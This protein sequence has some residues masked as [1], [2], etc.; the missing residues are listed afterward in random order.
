MRFFS[1]VLLAFSMLITS[2]DAETKILF[3][4]ADTP[5]PSRTIGGFEL[6]APENLQLISDAGGK[7]V[8]W[9]YSPT[10]GATFSNA[11]AG[12]EPADRLLE[13]GLIFFK[14]TMVLDAPNGKNQIKLWVG[15]WFTGIRRFTFYQDAI[16]IKIN[17]EQIFYT[18]LTPEVVFRD[19]WCRGED[20]LFS[21]NDDVW[22]RLVKPV[23]DEYSYEVEVTDGKIHLELDGVLLSALAITR[24]DQEMEI[25]S[26]TLEQERRQDFA[27]RYPWEPQPDEPLPP[28]DPKSEK[29][30]FL[31]FQKYGDDRVFPWSRPL[32]SELSDTVRVFAARGEQEIF[33]FG[34][35]PLRELKDFDV[36]IGDFVSTTGNKL[37]LAAH[38]DFWRERYKGRGSAGTRGK[39]SDIRRLD[40]ESYVLQSM[41]ALTYEQGTPRLF[42]LDVHVPSNQEAGDY[43]APV[44]FLE[45]GKP[46]GS[47]RLQLKVLPFDL[48]YDGAAAFNFQAGYLEF[49]DST[50]LASNAF[51]REQIRK[52]VEFIAKYHFSNNFQSM[53]GW[54]FPGIV[55]LGQITG[56][57]GERSF[58]QTPEQ[59][60]MADWWFKL[61]K[62]EGNTDYLML[63]TYS[64]FSNLG[65]RIGQGK[66][67]CYFGEPDDTP[68]TLALMRKDIVRIIKQF[69]DYG[70]ENGY[71][72]FRW[73]TTGE[74]DN[75]GIEGVK[76][77]I[78]FAEL[79]R[80]AGGIN[81][82]TINGPLAAKYC[83]EFFEYLSANF[84]TPITQ[85]L[86][87]EVE[88]YGHVF[89][90]HN[91]GDTRFQAGWHFWRM[92]GGFQTP[93]NDVLYVFP[94]AAC[95]TA[96]EL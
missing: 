69:N 90:A 25:V 38:T 78:K 87:D 36:S 81:L 86:I 64:L 71:P 95:L 51:L 46:V 3:G 48:H 84:A 8:P 42:T 14:T 58:T 52:R 4:P 62:N 67:K 32:A 56:N 45:N 92:G 61:L 7:A 41:R 76:E 15:D 68:E 1:V 83:P 91:T 17:G 82:T 24:T 43:F 73:Y 75:H 35:L 2:A 29:R 94:F 12:T 74:M 54:R 9:L 79:V 72:E 30:G 10:G 26:A 6:V 23:L 49:G 77:I 93:G 44:T 31:L 57:P 28:I 53:W 11:S 50:K 5:E 66:H 21:R 60:A 22:D 55:K 65:W 18:E 47:A 16:S 33:R 59:A 13:H 85:E 96:L 34:I 19:Y 37:P 20:Y 88:G 40:P 39:F 80:E 27:E 70:K 63:K 89:G